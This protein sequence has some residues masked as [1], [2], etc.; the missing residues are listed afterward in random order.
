MK[1]T[2]AS[3]LHFALLALVVIAVLG[4]SGCRKPLGFSE[5]STPSAESSHP[6]GPLDLGA[7]AVQTVSD[8]LK[9]LSQDNS[10]APDYDA[11]YNLLS[12][13]SQSMHTRASFE[14]DANRQGIPNFALNTAFTTVKNDNATVVLKSPD[15]DAMTHGFDLVREDGHWKIV[16]LGGGP[17]M[18]TAYK[19]QQAQKGEAK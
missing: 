3:W 1:R 15:E 9:A 10:H 16:Y 11:A 17:G 5:Q 13:D 12:R 19:P 2:L 18:P 14:A 6:S 8:Y 4:F 7:E